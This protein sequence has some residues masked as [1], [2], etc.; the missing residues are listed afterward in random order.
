A[1][2]VTASRHAKRLR[3]KAQ[4]ALTEAMQWHRKRDRR[5]ALRERQSALQAQLPSIDASRAVLEVAERA[6]TVAG[7]A[8]ALAVALG[9]SEQARRAE[10]AARAALAQLRPAA[11]A[12]EF[13]EFAELAT[14]AEPA[15]R[16]AVR[17]L[18]IVLGELAA[19]LDLESKH[20]VGH[21]EL[22]SLD[23]H[24]GALTTAVGAARGALAEF[25]QRR[26]VLNAELSTASV[27]AA[28]EAGLRAEQSRAVIRLRAA[29]QAAA[30]EKAA[31]RDEQITQ[32]ALTAYEDQAERYES[33][34]RS[35]RASVASTLG[36]ALTAGDPCEVCGSVEHPRPAARKADHVSEDVLSFA[37]DEL[38]RLRRAVDSA[39]AEL[40]QTRAEL[41]DLRAAADKL[42][43][44]Q[45]QSRVL[46]LDQAVA[47]AEAAAAEAIRLRT[48]LS[49]LDA[50]ERDLG[51]QL[52]A[53]DL[54]RAASAQQ[55]EAL[56]AAFA[57]EAERIET[58]RRGYASVAERAAAVL[59]QAQAAEQAAQVT[60]SAA[61][62][63]AHALDCGTRFQKALG[64][65]G[66]VDQQ[67]WQNARRTAAEISELR[68]ALRRFEDH[69]AEVRGALNEPELTDPALDQ[70]QA[71]LAPLLTQVADAEAA[72][73]AAISA[74]AVAQQN[75]SSV[76]RLGEALQEAMAA[77]ADILAETAAAIRIGSIAAGGGD[78]QLSM[79][80]TTYV[81]T[82]RFA[83]IMRAANT[84]LRQIS[85]GRYELEHSDSKQGNAKSGLG[86]RVMDLH[87]GRARDPATLSG[88]ETFYVSLSLALGLADVVR[89]ESGGVDLGTLFIDEGFGS[90]DPA[91]LDEVLRV[92]DSLRAGGRVVGVVSHVAEMK[93]RIADQIVIRPNPDGTS[94][95]RLIA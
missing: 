12:E 45:A 9:R 13:H 51:E 38:G 36:Q 87:T 35:W 52:H 55:A 70:P 20:A 58:A 61:E 53:A 17:A 31:A 3:A 74:R 66:F 47:A 40:D 1:S 62:A 32:A 89:A 26:A 72:E 83:D 81:L 64:E 24:V 60:A 88:G 43:P 86:V 23:H 41:A 77:G 39:R 37:Q 10:E 63:L 27:L 29:K 16:A 78:N 92:L 85:G 69:W 34:Q 75:L 28:T 82:R 79:E 7:P 46:E 54:E 48:Q 8:E 6:L 80:L 56:R 68:S 73:S 19:D 42:N 5:D 14:A 15:L 65:A 67:D 91:V 11:G 21:L 25:P 76:V 30:A 33:L 44:D 94:T 22:E 90:L 95:L 49:E 59:A 18:Q 57:S 2:A 84:Q 93:A 50:A 4:A 71:E